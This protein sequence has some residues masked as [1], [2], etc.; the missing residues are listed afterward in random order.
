MKKLLMFAA[1]MTIVGGAYAEC[2]DPDPVDSNCVAV[3]NVKMNLK[4]TTGKAYSSKTYNA[5]DCSELEVGG[6]VRFPKAGLVLEGYLIICDCTCAGMEEA[7]E[8]TLFIGNKKLQSVIIPDSFGFDFLHILGNGKSAETSWKLEGADYTGQIGPLALTGAGFGTYSTKY[9]V[10]SSFSGAAVGTLAEPVCLGECEAAGY[11]LC[12]GSFETTDPS[13]LFGTWG[14]KLN[15]KYSGAKYASN[16]TA[17]YN[18]LFPAWAYN[19]F[20][21]TP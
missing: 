18:A 20:F 9:N 21:G 19:Q 4:T 3:Y 11:W 8:D 13:V 10:Y 14:M 15:T 17:L 7:D 2:S 12:D 1:A 6:C 5:S 16:I